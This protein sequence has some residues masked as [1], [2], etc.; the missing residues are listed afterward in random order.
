MTARLQQ[1]EDFTL[2][3]A[4]LIWF[5]VQFLQ[6]LWPPSETAVADIIDA[7]GYRFLQDDLGNVTLAACWRLPPWQQVFRPHRL[8]KRGRE[9]IVSFM[10]TKVQNEDEIHEEVLCFCV[11]DDPSLAK[12]QISRT[13]FFQL[14][15]DYE[16]C[17][18][19]IGGGYIKL[20]QAAS[21]AWRL[22]GSARTQMP[23]PQLRQTRTALQS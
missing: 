4:S 6:G 23:T 10:I 5:V 19:E 21:P 2:T 7:Q 13:E 20:S 14:L 17:F 16:G 3:S 9:R 8:S 12:R 22:G 1:E 15:D 18:K 11:L